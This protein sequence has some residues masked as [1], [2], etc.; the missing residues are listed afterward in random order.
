MENPTYA[1]RVPA[2]VLTAHVILGSLQLSVGVLTIVF[3]VAAVVTGV[4]MTSVFAASGIWSAPFF[5]GAGISG[6]VAGKSERRCTLGCVVTCL[7]FSILASVFSAIALIMVAFV[8]S[9]SS[10][11]HS[12]YSSTENFV[13]SVICCLLLAAEFL[14]AVVHSA[15]ACKAS[16][17]CVPDIQLNREQQRQT[18]AYVV[19]GGI[20]PREQQV[21]L[22][23]GYEHQPVP[24]SSFQQPPGYGYGGSNGEVKRA[25]P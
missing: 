7:V 3:S 5:I 22:H 24:N 15:F 11:V 19:D 8:L 17:C 1:S 14:L 25:L 21:F 23:N 13:M 12:S 2:G 16:C 4:N 6:L 20:V 18:V 10:S 9:L